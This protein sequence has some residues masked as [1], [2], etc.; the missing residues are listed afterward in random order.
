ML[1]DCQYKGV[2]LP[3]KVVSNPFGL[4]ILPSI[5]ITL[6]KS[7]TTCTQHSWYQGRWSRTV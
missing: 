5:A 4:Q 3:Q 7:C 1:N 2:I 6:L